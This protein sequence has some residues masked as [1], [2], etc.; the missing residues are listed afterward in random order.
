MKCHSIRTC[1]GVAVLTAGWTTAVGQTVTV[2][3]LNDVV[4]FGGARQVVNLPGP[5]GKV[6]F[7]EALEAT[8]NTPGPQTIAFAI[9]QS[10]WW[11]FNNMALLRLENGAFLINDNE[12]TVDFTTQTAFTGD[13][14]P[15]GWEVGIYGLEPNGWG[16]AAIYL[17]GNNC[18]IKGLDRVMQRGYAVQ[19]TGDNNHVIAC[20]I[21]GPL[22]AGIYI[23]G[24]FSGPPASGN[25]VGGTQPGEGNQLSAGNSGVRIDAPADGNVV[26]GNT[27][28]GAFAGIEVRAPSCCPQLVASNNRIGGPSPQERNIISGAGHFGEEG[29]PVGEQVSL[30]LAVNT[31]VEGNYIG[32]NA[33]GTAA[34][35]QIGPTGINVRDCSGTVIRNNV[36]SGLIGAGTGPHYA[37]QFFGLA[38]SVNGNSSN[39]VLAGNRIGTNAAGD[40]PI[41]NYRGLAFAYFP[42]TGNPTNTTLGGLLTGEGN[43]IAFNQVTGV[44]VDGTVS[45]VRMLGNAIYSNGGMGI[46]LITA[47]GAPGVTPNDAGDADTGG[48][49]LQNFPV[50]ASAGSDGVAAT[51]V[52]GTLNSLANTDFLVQFFAN[53]ACDASGFGEGQDYLGSTVVTTNAGG[54]A[55]FNVM[56]PVGV[57]AG[58]V[59][60]A[61]ATHQVTGN[62]SEFSACVAVS[63]AAPAIVAANP[64]AASPY[65][66]GQPFRDVLQTGTGSLLTQGIGAPDTPGEDAIEF[67]QISVTF[68]GAPNPAPAVGNVTVACTDVTGNGPADCPV[69]THVT[70]AGSGPYVMT[71]S[72]AI[73]PRECT[74]FTFAGTSAGQKLQYQSLSG[75]LT[76]DGSSNTQDLLALVQALNN[77]SANQP[78][79]WARYNVDRS[80][81]PTGRVNTQD[82][83]REVQLLNGVNTTQVFSGATVAACP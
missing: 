25:V 13:T 48:N 42:T 26:I 73:P 67:A 33:D 70:G 41:P 64:P 72:G 35:P 66:P 36:I 1:A 31:I 52:E 79:N 63:L 5:D 76:L 39:T 21:S 55:S 83:L 2:T 74:T 81:Q 54:N 12:T 68:S 11:L 27:L 9:P 44:R 59:M 3:T 56:L 65:Q 30:I 50:I 10:E 80:S 77:G 43:T 4:D 45:G 34:A 24:G 61:T 58:Q 62:S 16:G 57:S 19:I 37:G 46:D 18:T 14:N 15:N 60:T 71:L 40:G 51:Y 78:T 7:R 23:N 49:G 28:T 29:F 38:V 47:L 6:S 69:I 20:T 17:N 53:E 8:D 32:T 22:Y 82:L 75:D